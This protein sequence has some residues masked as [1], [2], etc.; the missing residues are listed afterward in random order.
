[1]VS[2]AITAVISIAAIMLFKNAIA[3][4]RLVS[5]IQRADRIRATTT[6][7]IQGIAD[8]TPRVDGSFSGAG[9]SV[10]NIASPGDVPILQMSRSLYGISSS[11]TSDGLVDGPIDIDGQYYSIYQVN[12]DLLSGNQDAHENFVQF[13]ARFLE[14]QLRPG[15]SDFNQLHVDGVFITDTSD[16]N[17][18]RLASVDNSGSHPLRIEGDKLYIPLLYQGI[19]PPLFTPLARLSLSDK[20][21][22]RFVDSGNSDGS[23]Q[24]VLQRFGP[25]NTPYF[26]QVLAS[27]VKDFSV[28]FGFIADSDSATDIVLP[29]GRLSHISDPDYLANLNGGTPVAWKNISDIRISYKVPLIGVKSEDLGTNSDGRFAFDA[30][31]TAYYRV[32]DNI[33]L[34]LFALDRGTLSSGIDSGNSIC[35]RGDEHSKESR[36]RPECS[37][38]FDQGGLL[39]SDPL[40]WNWVG[41]GDL[42]SDYCIASIWHDT[43]G[44]QRFTPAEDVNWDASKLFSSREIAI[45]SEFDLRIEAAIHHFGP[46]LPN[47]W[48][49]Y[50]PAKWAL[51]KWC[52]QPFNLFEQQSVGNHRWVLN[53][54][55]LNNRL[56]NNGSYTI[57]GTGTC[58]S[59]GSGCQPPVSGA[60][61]W[62]LNT[63]NAASCSA[64]S[65]T[66]DMYVEDYL[67]VGFPDDQRN[68]YS[69]YLGSDHLR[70]FANKCECENVLLNSAGDSTGQVRDPGLLNWRSVCNLQFRAN[71]SNSAACS[72]FINSGASFT[73]YIL[74]EDT[75]R[76]GLTEGQISM[77]ECL[78]GR[79]GGGNLDSPMAFDFRDS[80]DWVNDPINQNFETNYNSLYSVDLSTLDGGK[81]ASNSST[82]ATAT[83]AFSTDPSNPRSLPVNSCAATWCDMRPNT[84]TSACCYGGNPTNAAVLPAYSQWSGYCRNT[85]ASS[86]PDR[87]NIRRLITNTASD[88]DFPVS[89]GG[90]SNSGGGGDNGTLY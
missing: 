12:F 41:Y 58:S 85:C 21:Q 76:V 60:N 59:N 87:D 62:R 45:G 9:A 83:Y 32:E 10:A 88:S 70:L 63:P 49:S 64:S 66:C 86:V 6:K 53:T 24:I 35:P 46:S 38:I 26:S 30:D 50:A 8:S 79:Y 18:F 75:S 51:A 5:Q 84:A 73:N 43:H 81:R 34:P 61:N 47:V 37:S 2:L 80:M 28:S 22:I 69:S 3:P 89:C 39:D 42:N 74:G 7:V 48:R 17:H 77:C 44:N 20:T 4:Q 71:P 36:C 68:T 23:G 13:G 57:P 19:N 1:M 11:F 15:L 33:G 55:E 82:S 40:P 27:Q 25:N 16:V 31:G 78:Y 72:Q 54:T 29:S 56:A 90:T 52:L 67:R 14:N 65:F